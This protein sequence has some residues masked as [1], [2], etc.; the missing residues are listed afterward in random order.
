MQFKRA[1]PPPPLPSAL[2]SGADALI[3]R[4]FNVKS[5][6]LEQTLSMWRLDLELLLSA[7]PPSLAPSASIRWPLSPDLLCHLSCV[8]LGCSLQQPYVEVLVPRADV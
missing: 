6:S 1:L 8:R 2:L 5:A 7:L 3:Q 4:G